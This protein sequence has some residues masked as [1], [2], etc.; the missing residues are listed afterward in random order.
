MDTLHDPIKRRCLLKTG[1]LKMATE[2][3]G[4][5]TKTWRKTI[6]VAEI[7]INWNEAKDIANVRSRRPKFVVR[8]PETNRR[9]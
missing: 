8:C 9:N 6:N 3:M 4:W 1:C 7:E 2:R 5:P